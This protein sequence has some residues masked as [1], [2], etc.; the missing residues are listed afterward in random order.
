M[1]GDLEPGRVPG[2]VA[3]GGSALHPEGALV[4]GDVS[5]DIQ[6]KPGLREDA[7]VTPVEASEEVEAGRVRPQAHRLGDDAVANAPHDLQRP[8]LDRK[9]TRLN[10]S[11]V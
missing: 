3:V 6:R 8:A 2:R 5:A 7:P 4:G 10:S 1:R 9:S 11:H